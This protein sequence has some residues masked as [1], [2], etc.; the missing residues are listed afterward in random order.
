VII[1][2]IDLNPVRPEAKKNRAG[3]M[4][5]AVGAARGAGVDLR[6]GDVVPVLTVV[7]EFPAFRWSCSAATLPV[8]ELVQ[9]CYKPYDAGVPFKV[10]SVCLPF[11]YAKRPKGELSILDIRKKQLIRLD[12]RTA[13]GVW[14]ILSES[15]KKKKKRKKA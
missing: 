2:L 5:E 1:P 10:V 4:G 12:R 13:R 15:K 7:V 11:V 14:A 3:A 9:L 6:S 8:D